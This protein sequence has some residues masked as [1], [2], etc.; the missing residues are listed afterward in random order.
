MTNPYNIPK[1]FLH[2]LAEWDQVIETE[3]GRQEPT[4]NLWATASLFTWRYYQGNSNA[5]EIVLDCIQAG[6][7]CQNPAPLL[8][9]VRLGQNEAIQ[10]CITFIQGGLMRKMDE[11]FKQ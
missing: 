8:M 11:A 1:Q 7:E 6:G 2:P 9:K 5:E 3:D 10:N 4:C